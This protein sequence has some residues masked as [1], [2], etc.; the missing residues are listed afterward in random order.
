MRTRVYKTLVGLLRQS[1]YEQLSFNDIL[2]GRFYDKS[3]EWCPFRLSDEAL[4]EFAFG[5]CAALNMRDKD[6]VL[7]NV[8]TRR[9][10]SC[11]ILDR[12]YV[13]L[14]KKELHYGYCAG[15]DYTS[16]TRLVRKLLRCK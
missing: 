13:S 10:K 7:R 6:D 3:H 5:V 15:Q 14:Y 8:A 2:G 16:E 11:G 9:V 12:L 1:Y 4:K